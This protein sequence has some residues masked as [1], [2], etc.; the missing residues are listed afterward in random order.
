MDNYFVISTSKIPEVING[1][2]TSDNVN[3]I[4]IPPIRLSGKYTWEVGLERL[5]T[6]NSVHNVKAAYNNNIIRYSP[7]GGTT[8]KTITI[9][10]GNYEIADL[11]IV[12]H[13]RMYDD[14]DC[15]K[16]N[17]L[18]PVFY[19]NFIPLIAEGR[20]RIEISNN[21]QLDLTQGEL[22]TILGFD[23]VIIG[24]TS[25]GPNGVDIT[26]GIDSWSVHCSIIGGSY[27][28]SNR[29]D[30]IYGFVPTTGRGM[31]VNEYPARVSYYPLNRTYANGHDIIL[32]E[33]R[34]SLT[35]QLDRPILLNGSDI[36]YRLHIRP[37]KARHVNG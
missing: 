2:W 28:N 19:I 9:P 7:N 34:M 12:L 30:I 8:W 13:N 11:D 22:H 33:I 10:D 27:D 37:T 23:A 5:D 20:L 25:T 16:S 24:S 18:E 3:T 26:R 32:N 35:D 31:A 29:A 6:W 17:P 4:Y 21:Y 14:G 15:D 1:I 36:T